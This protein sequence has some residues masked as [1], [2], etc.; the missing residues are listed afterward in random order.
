MSKRPTLSL[1]RKPEST[2]PQEETTSLEPQKIKLD[3]VTYRAEQK[4]KAY[5]ERVKRQN[6]ILNHLNQM[7]LKY[8]L[9]KGTGVTIIAS[10]VSYTHLTLPTIYSV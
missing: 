3:P 7:N 9:S 4:K 8:P 10:P 5:A 2:L 6:D 1:K